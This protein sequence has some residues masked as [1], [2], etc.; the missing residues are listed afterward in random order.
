M[1]ALA[2]QHAT[3]T[4]KVRWEEQRKTD[5]ARSQQ[6]GQI[7]EYEDQLARKRYNSEHEATR[8][9]NAEMVK[10]QRMPRRGRSRCEGRRRNRFSSRGARRI[11]KS[12][13]ASASSSAPSPSPKPRAASRR[14]GRTRT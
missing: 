6:Q 7:K 9:R 11:G 8:Q 14:T 2:A 3:N 12:Q 1:Q 4:E 10:M 5:E 13:S